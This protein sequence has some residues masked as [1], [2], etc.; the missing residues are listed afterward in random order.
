LKSALSETQR[1]REYAPR[2]I[3]NLLVNSGFEVE[4]LETGEFRELPHPEHGW[5]EHLLKRYGLN[6]TL[7]GDGVYAL[8][9]KNGPVRERYPEWLYS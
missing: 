8:G 1:D 3:H 7:R 2:E 9:R 6:A 4:R 5:V